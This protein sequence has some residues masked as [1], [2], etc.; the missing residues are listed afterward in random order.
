M[1]EAAVVEFP[2]LGNASV[3]DIDR[4]VSSPVFILTWNALKHGHGPQLWH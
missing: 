2:S 3:S 4:G 1:D